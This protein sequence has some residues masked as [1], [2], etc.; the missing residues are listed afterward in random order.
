M[1]FVQA[2]IKGIYIKK[3]T[4][5]LKN[6]K[7]ACIGPYQKAL[8]L[9]CSS[10]GWKISLVHEKLVVNLNDAL[11]FLHKHTWVLSFFCLEIC[12][13]DFEEINAAEA[14]MTCC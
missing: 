3:R 4:N 5:S 12:F 1:E 11:C 8:Y 14:R 9:S 6:K 7:E 10:R 2:R 13:L